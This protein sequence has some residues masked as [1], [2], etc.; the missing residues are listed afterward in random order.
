MS[1]SA[2]SR[3]ASA[4]LVVFFEQP[5]LGSV[6]RVGGKGSNL[7]ALANAGFPVPPGIVVTADAYQLFLEGG[8]RAVIYRQHQGFV[9]HEARM[10]VVIQRQ[11]E[12]Q[13]AGVGFSINPVSGRFDRLVIDANYGLGESV[14]G[15]EYEID[16]FE[17]DKETLAVVE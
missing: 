5:E 16:H 7:I 9:Q 14:V 11:I 4:N 17:L 2:S 8:D 15:G 10:A 3:P 13:V 12:C 6:C 1:T